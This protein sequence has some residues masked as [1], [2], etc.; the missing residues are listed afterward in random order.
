M[1]SEGGSSKGTILRSR[2][3]PT[4]GTALAVTPNRFVEGRG[5]S[6]AVSFPKAAGL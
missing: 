1:L 2:S 4:P 3:I 5:F 6:R